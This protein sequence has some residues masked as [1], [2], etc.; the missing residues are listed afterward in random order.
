ML[1]KSC[2]FHSDSLQ[3]ILLSRYFLP[4]MRDVLRD[5]FSYFLVIGNGNWEQSCV[6]SFSYV[7]S[8]KAIN[9]FHVD[10]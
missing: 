5:L 7:F 8:V 3:G 10:Y 2:G 4:Q 1:L 6:I 9:V